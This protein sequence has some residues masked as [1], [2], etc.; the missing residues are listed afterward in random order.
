MGFDSDLLLLACRELY[1]WQHGTA[2]GFHTSLFDL[3]GRAD[4]NNR[5]KIAKGFPHE[6]QAYAAWELS[7]DPEQFFKD[8]N[9]FGE[10]RV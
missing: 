4:M 6:V 1:F 5:M 3:I 8:L 10:D 2:S 7:K 9:L